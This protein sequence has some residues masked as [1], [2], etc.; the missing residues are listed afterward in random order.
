MKKISEPKGPGEFIVLPAVQRQANRV[1]EDIPQIG[2]FVCRVL[3]VD[4]ISKKMDMKID[5]FSV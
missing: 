3:I 1:F 5:K 2:E 4:I